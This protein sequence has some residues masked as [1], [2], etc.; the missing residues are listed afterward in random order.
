MQNATFWFLLA[1][2][3]LLVF[4]HRENLKRLVQGNESRFEK[5]RLLHRFFAK[6][7]S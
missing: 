2:G 7:N 5:V 6:K 4:T 3:L 1:M